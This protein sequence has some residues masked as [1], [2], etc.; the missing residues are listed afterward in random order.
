MHWASYNGLNHA[1]EVEE[2]PP[3]EYT[4][5]MCCPLPPHLQFYNAF[6]PFLLHL[7]SRNEEASML[8]IP[9]SSPNIYGSSR[10][11]TIF[12]V[13]VLTN[14]P[15]LTKKT[16]LEILFPMMMDHPNPSM[17]LHQV[18]KQM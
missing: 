17:P 13:Q 6:D 16:N 2:H 5:L 15:P 14:L 10:L 4:T 18:T 9:S 12:Q 8:Y 1:Q 7:F 3:I 11:S